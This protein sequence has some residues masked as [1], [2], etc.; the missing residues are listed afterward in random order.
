MTDHDDDP[1]A[2][3]LRRALAQALGLGL[4]DDR[5]GYA[6]AHGLRIGPRDGHG[7]LDP[8]RTAQIVRES[9]MGQ[10]IV[11]TPKDTD[12]ARH[13]R[14]TA[15]MSPREAMNYARQHRLT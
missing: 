7:R 12:P 1:A 8:L 9:E 5:M 15:N 3:E 14:A 2:L 10:N 11:A 13:V 6:I 4:D